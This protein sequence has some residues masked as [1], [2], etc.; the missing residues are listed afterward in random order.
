MQWDLLG[1]TLRKVRN[2]PCVPAVLVVI[3]PEVQGRSMWC[4]VTRFR[5][6]RE[7]E[8]GFTSRVI[9]ELKSCPREGQTSKSLCAACREGPGRILRM[10]QLP[11]ATR[12]HCSHSFMPSC[13]KTLILLHQS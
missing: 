8:L 9:W 5:Y 2:L 12:G 11:A 1:E 7:D 13:S 6:R 3:H 10:S 4:F